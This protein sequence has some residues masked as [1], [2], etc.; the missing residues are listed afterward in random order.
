MRC[1]CSG[2]ENV[3]NLTAQAPKKEQ[4]DLFSSCVPVSVDRVDQDKGADKNVDADQSRTERP[5][6]SEQSI[7]LFTQREEINIDFGVSG[8]PLRL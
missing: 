4:G 1:E 8:L 7:D 6:E 5:V 2:I 3:S